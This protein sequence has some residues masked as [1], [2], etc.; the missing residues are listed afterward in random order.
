MLK[1]QQLKNLAKSITFEQQKQICG[2]DAEDHWQDYSAGKLNIGK[3]IQGDEGENTVAISF[4][5]PESGVPKGSIAIIDGKT[6]TF[7]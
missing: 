5:D 4:I 6:Y 7:F 2:G 1:I 3:T